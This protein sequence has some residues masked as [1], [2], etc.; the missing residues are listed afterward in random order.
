M[1]ERTRDHLALLRDVRPTGL[2]ARRLALVVVLASVACA[3]PQ[4]ASDPLRPVVAGPRWP[5]KTREHVDL[6]FHGF[7]MLMDDTAR[8]P[9]FD[10]GYRDRLTVERNRRGLYTALD[11]ARRELVAGL[12]ALRRSRGRSSSGSTSAAGRSSSAG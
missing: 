9:L 6:W 1:R 7:A 10:R 5:V 12:R 2:I 8:V 3:G 11:S 4:R